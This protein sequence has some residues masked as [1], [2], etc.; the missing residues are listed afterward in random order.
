M[1]AHTIIIGGTGMLR[2]AAVK[3]AVQSRCLTSIARTHR[4]LVA[5][6][7]MLPRSH[8]THHMLKLDW[9]DPDPFLDGIEQHVE[10][11]EPPDLVLAWIHEEQ[12]ALRLASR[13]GTYHLQ[14]FHVIGSARAD[15]AAVAAKALSE[16]QVPSNVTYHQIIL[17]AHGAGFNARW[18]TDQEIS[19]GT[20]E[21]IQAKLPQF[22]VGKL[23]YS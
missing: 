21:A 4:S 3:L 20:L 18:L 23:R 1:H 10:K 12:L 17:G 8:G 19:D 16:I 22:I 13:L 11:T 14:F 2:A 5:L 6:D 9:S 7:D 15:P